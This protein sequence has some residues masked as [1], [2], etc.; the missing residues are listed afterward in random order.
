M[1][2]TRTI[3]DQYTVTKTQEPKENWTLSLKVEKAKDCP[4]RKKNKSLCL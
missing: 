4:K 1:C 2:A 3:S